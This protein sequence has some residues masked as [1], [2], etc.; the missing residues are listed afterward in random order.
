LVIEASET[1]DSRLEEFEDNIYM[2]EQI[3]EIIINK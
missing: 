1:M 2:E 3:E